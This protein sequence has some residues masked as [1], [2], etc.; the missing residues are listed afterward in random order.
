MNTG[1][2]SFSNRFYKF[3]SFRECRNTLRRLS[4]HDRSMLSE[5]L[6]D[7]IA[8]L[9][10][11]LLVKYP[12]RLDLRILLELLKCFLSLRPEYPVYARFANIIAKIE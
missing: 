4:N 2:E 5:H 9:V 7:L 8:Q 12:A 3:K 11:R 6:V 10:E 1:S